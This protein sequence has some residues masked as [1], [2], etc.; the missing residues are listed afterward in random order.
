MPKL[1]STCEPCLS[2]QDERNRLPSSLIRVADAEDLA[3]KMKQL[4]LLPNETRTQMGKNARQK[5]VKE[6]D[7]QFVIEAYLNAIEKETSLSIRDSN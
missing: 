7:K 4:I 3:D 6:F 1:S 2:V 5:V